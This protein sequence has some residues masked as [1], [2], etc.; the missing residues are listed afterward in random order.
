[1]KSALVVIGVAFVLFQASFSSAQSSAISNG[2]SYL[3][4]SQTPTGY[5][6]AANEV[7][8]NTFVDT[9]AASETLRY[10]NGTD[11]AYTS[12]IQWINTTMVSN[13]DYLLSQLLTLSQ[14]GQ[15]VTSIRDYL[16]SIRNSDGG[17]GV[18]EGITSDIKRTAL[19]L[20]ALK[21]VNYSDY[22][23]LFQAV[24]FLTTNQNS[25]GGWGYNPGEG[26]NVYITSLVLKTLCF[27]SA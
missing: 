20:Q 8:Y 21:A 12:A 5:W 18:G 10:F 26:S 23:V 15:D 11:T 22:S 14:A 7:P 16:L 24:N 3:L 25:D 2:L 1:M 19:A 13:N 17:W 9:C 4:S 27:G 6:G